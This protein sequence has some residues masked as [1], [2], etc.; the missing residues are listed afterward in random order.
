MLF[1]SFFFNLFYKLF[2]FYIFTLTSIFAI[3]SVLLF[4][5]IEFYVIFKYLIFQISE[6][7]KNRNLYVDSNYF[8][9]SNTLFGLEKFSE[10]SVPW[11]VDYE[12]S[13]WGSDF[14]AQGQVKQISERERRFILDELN[15]NHSPNLENLDVREG[16]LSGRLLKAKF[17]VQNYVDTFSFF[18]NN[19]FKLS[20]IFRNKSV[21]S[22]ESEYYNLANVVTNFFRKNNYKVYSSLGPLSQEPQPHWFSNLKKNKEFVRSF[23]P[24]MEIK[25]DFSLPKKNNITNENFKKIG[26]ISDRKQTVFRKL[27][28]SSTSLDQTFGIKSRA[29]DLTKESNYV[30]ERQLQSSRSLELDFVEFLKN[31]AVCRFDFYYPNSLDINSLASKPFAFERNTENG[32]SV[33][34]YFN[35]KGHSTNINRYSEYLDTRFDSYDVNLENLLKYWSNRDFQHN[36]VE[37]RDTEFVYF[38]NTNR[39]VSGFFLLNNQI[40]EVLHKLLIN[41]LLGIGMFTYQDLDSSSGLDDNVQSNNFLE[42]LLTYR[43]EYKVSHW[44]NTKNKFFFYTQLREY[45]DFHFNNLSFEDK[46]CIMA[47]MSL[48]GIGVWFDFES[49]NIFPNTHD[50]FRL[51][52]SEF[53]C[54]YKYSYNTRTEVSD[55]I[56]LMLTNNKKIPYG[57]N[58]KNHEI[59]GSYKKYILRSFC[60]LNKVY[61][62]GNQF[63][64]IHKPNINNLAH[65]PPFV[66]NS[67]N[68]ANLL[69]DK[70]W[71]GKINSMTTKKYFVVT[72]TGDYLFFFKKNFFFK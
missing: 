70:L 12:D 53:L 46:K 44:W 67:T 39:F 50:I 64:N 11:L 37:F 23:L 9:T 59:F 40:S 51:A 21:Y 43:L 65:K 36:F 56:N 34:F 26:E 57:A 27:T 35:L 66:N 8:L 42:K 45:I 32:K 31:R 25:N 1:F 2:F 55:K 58:G 20:G 47:G 30:F 3:T 13:G 7:F 10:V 18:F 69:I 72:I 16:S 14:D 61:S 15:L 48:F 54:S 28:D 24:K 5:D 4:K 68:Y 6:S 63:T 62:S 22:T 17:R 71:V 60:Y 41:N 38:K 19:F 33:D 52:L 49:R 29:P